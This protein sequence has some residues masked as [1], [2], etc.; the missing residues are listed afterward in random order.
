[1]QIPTALIRR[2]SIVNGK[3]VLLDG[4]DTRATPGR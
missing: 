1:M 3:P 2:A 4:Q